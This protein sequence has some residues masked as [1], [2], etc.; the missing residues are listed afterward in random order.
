VIEFRSGG[1]SDTGQVRT[2]NQ[3]SWVATD[4]LYVVADGMGG[5]LGGEVASL[6]AVETIRDRVEQPSMSSLLEGVRAANEAIFDRA[7]DDPDLRGMGTTVCTIAGVD[8]EDGPRLGVVNVGDSRIYVFVGEELRQVTQDHSLVETMV[9]EGRLTEEEAAVHPQRNIVTRALGVGP[10]LEID[11][12]QLPVR[13]GDRFIL[14]SDGLFNEVTDDQIAAVLRRLADPTEAA[15]ELVRLANANGGRDNITVLIVDVE[16]GGDDED[17]DPVTTSFGDP[18]VARIHGTDLAGF[19]TAVDPANDVVSD[20]DERS[21]QPAVDGDDG[22]EPKG[23]RRLMS[24]RAFGWLVMVIGVIVVA[25]AAIGIYA[26]S[27][28]FVSVEGDQIVIFQGRPDGV[29]WFDP[30]IEE[31]TEVA[32][33]D[34]TPALLEEVVGNPSYA[35]LDGAQDYVAGL[36]DR[37]PSPEP[38]PVPETPAAGTPTPDG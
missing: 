37:L 4:G 12:W 6:I 1:A 15:E 36:I 7:T 30:T 8:T 16:P 5:H 33:D 29:L 32:V 31:V 3:D 2:V 26:R 38:T 17:A 24:W 28:F 23:H 10:D 34:L 20:D 25:V 27:S 35:S 14:C 9:R 18:R 19:S 22:D 11:W 21:L 13:S